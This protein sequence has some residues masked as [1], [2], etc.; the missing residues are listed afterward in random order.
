[1]EFYHRIRSKSMFRFAK[2]HLEMRTRFTRPHSY[3]LRLIFKKRTAGRGL[4]RRCLKVH[5][6]RLIDSKS[7]C[8]ACNRL[9]WECE[10]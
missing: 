8:S 7:V 3:S 10:A 5:P 1:M 9:D 4:A 6:L 2:A